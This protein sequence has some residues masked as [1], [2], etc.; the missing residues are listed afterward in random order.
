MDL[1]Y[2]TQAYHTLITSALIHCDNQNVIQ[3]AHNDISY[4]HTKHIDIDCHL[5]RYHLFQQTLR[6]VRIATQ[7]QKASIFTKFILS[8]RGGVKKNNNDA[9]FKIIKYGADYVKKIF[10][11]INHCADYVNKIFIIWL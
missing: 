10:K 8:L 2:K 4:G 9:D 7:A 6:L 3:V 5:I 11:I 1:Q